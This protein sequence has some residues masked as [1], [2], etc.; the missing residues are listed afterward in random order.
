M[1]IEIERKFLIRL[2]KRDDLTRAGAVSRFIRQT[3]L[4][5]G[6][7]GEERRIRE[8]T[9]SGKTT[10]IY[11]EKTKITRVSRTEDEREITRDEYLSLRR[12]AKTELTKTRYAFPYEGHTVEIDVYPPEIGGEK[13]DGYAVLEVELGDEKEAF[14]LPDFIET[15]KELTGGREFSNKALARPV[16]G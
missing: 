10:Y 7:N 11:T 4:R 2:P 6:E 12:E 13:M 8:V 15:V 16:E 9:E 1:H 3:Y 5:D 14:S